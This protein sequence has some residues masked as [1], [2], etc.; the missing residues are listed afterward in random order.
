MSTVDRETRFCISCGT[1]GDHTSLD[2]Y[3]PIKRTIVH[4]RIKEAREKRKASQHAHNRD[5]N[6]LKNAFDLSNHTWPKLNNNEHHKMSTILKL[7]LL[8]EAV[9]A[10]SFQSNLTKACHDN[11]LPNIIYTPH[12]DTVKAI[13]DSMTKSPDCIC[14][15]RPTPK[16]VKSTLT[17]YTR[18]Q[19]KRLGETCNTLD[20]EIGCTSLSMNE[21]K[22]D[23]LIKNSRSKSLQNI[24][25]SISPETIHNARKQDLQFVTPDT[26]TS[27]ITQDNNQTHIQESTDFSHHD[28]C[29]TL[30][31]SINQ[32]IPLV[33]TIIQHGLPEELDIYHMFINDSELH[34]Y[35]KRKQQEQKLH[36]VDLEILQTLTN[37]DCKN[38]LFT[39]QFKLEKKRISRQTSLTDSKVYF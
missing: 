23:K 26:P 39:D 25:L 14:T 15:S 11:D 6:L 8:D 28:S 33:Q 3:C 4:N 38:N 21:F 29:D 9:A 32:E 16:K 13:F 18:D 31:H 19:Y 10:G 34:D 2:P 20:M 7:T 27:L 36:P 1:R 24:T 35:L 12:P 17:K 22:Q 37:S 5:L 30:D